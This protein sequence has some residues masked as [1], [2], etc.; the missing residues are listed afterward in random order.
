MKLDDSK[1]CVPIWMV[2]AQRGLFS[3]A[4]VRIGRWGGM[5]GFPRPNS[6]DVSLLVDDNENLFNILFGF[7]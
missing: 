1:L 2:H 4:G 3:A 6:A 5:M 7:Y